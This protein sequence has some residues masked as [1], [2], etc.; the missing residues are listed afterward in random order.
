MDRVETPYFSF[1]SDDD[2][3]LP[4]FY[5]AALANL[6]SHPEAMF[7]SHLTL[8]VDTDG[9][10]K[11]NRTLGWKSGYYPPTGGLLTFLR[12]GFLTWTA[13]LFRRQAIEKVGSLD[14][15]A[16][17]YCDTDFV[18]RSVS[19]FPFVVTARPGAVFMV[20]PGSSAFTTRFESIW[21]GLTRVIR[22]IS[23][24]AEIP[25]D[26][27]EAMRH[28]LTAWHIKVISKWVVQFALKK[29]YES[30][31]K[32]ARLLNELYRLNGRAFALTT[33]ARVCRS[34]PPAH[35]GCRALDGLRKAIINARIGKGGTSE[36]IVRQA[37]AL[38]AKEVGADAR[39]DAEA[40]QTLGNEVL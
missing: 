4:G 40:K 25:K 39:L 38:E 7:S 8:V 26:R 13:M 22:K 15:E 37:F 2:L 19:R 6:E 12:D 18:L 27:R 33:F 20:H 28:V 11:F 14:T 35:W 1:L 30:A 16:L 3:L 9:R 32:T 10:S 29:D 23:E 5:Q 21:P 36:E 34:F 31:L 17:G 24:D